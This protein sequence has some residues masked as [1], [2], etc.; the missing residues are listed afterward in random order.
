MKLDLISLIKIYFQMK[1][2]A[3]AFADLGKLIAQN[4]KALPE[5][6][7]AKY[8]AEANIDKAR[9]QREVEERNADMPPEPGP[10]GRAGES[11]STEPAGPNIRNKR[12]GEGVPGGSEKRAK[13]SYGWS[14]YQD[15]GQSG[16]QHY[17]QST[18]GPPPYY[19][20]Y[21]GYGRAGAEGYGPPPPPPPGTFHRCTCVFID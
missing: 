1:S 5:S 20:P 13:T 3:I 4:W 12:L 18:R 6:E 9:Y 16:E 11:V 15:E 14:G 8:T 7:R 2:G 17:G 19:D 10:S 21:F